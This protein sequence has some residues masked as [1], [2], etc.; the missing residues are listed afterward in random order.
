[1]IYMKTEQSVKRNVLMLETARWP[2]LLVTLNVLIR[3]NSFFVFFLSPSIHFYLCN[4]GSLCTNTNP[5]HQHCAVF[6]FCFCFFPQFS[7]QY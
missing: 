2:E 6:C 4:L 5:F 1:M 7:H 3:F